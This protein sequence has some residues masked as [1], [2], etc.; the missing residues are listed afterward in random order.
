MSRDAD[1]VLVVRHVFRASADFLFDAW[2]D[3][4]MMARWFHARPDWTTEVV[5]A[6]ARV[7]GRWEIVMHA[8]EGPDCRAFGKYLAIERPRRLVFTWHA[9]ADENYETVVTLTFRPVDR[10][11]TELVLSQSGL[12]NDE[13]RSDH[14]RGWE[15][16]LSCLAQFAD[17]RDDVEERRS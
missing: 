7:G 17:I 1:V 2:I 11:T 10:D 15:G 3:P 9:N 8:T 16:C 5:A 13:D 4:A 12:R 14:A 6:D